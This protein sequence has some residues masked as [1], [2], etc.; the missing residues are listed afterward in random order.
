MKKDLFHIYIRNHLSVFYLPI[1]IAGIVLWLRFY[2]QGYPSEQE[3]K[4]GVTLLSVSAIFL[5]LERRFFKKILAVKDSDADS[6]LPIVKTVFLKAFYMVPWLMVVFWPYQTDYML[7]HILGFIF[8]FGAVGLYV[9][10][11]S[12][13]FVLFLTDVLF[14]VAAASVILFLNQDSIE[15]N[16]IFSALVLFTLYAL[17]IGRRLNKTSQELVDTNFKLVEA[18]SEAKNANMAKSDFLSMISHEIRTPMHGILSTVEHLAETDLSDQQKESLSVVSRCSETLLNMLNNILDISK[19]EAKKTEIEYVVFSLRTVIEDAV[20][21]VKHSAAEKGLELKFD[22]DEAVPDYIKSDQVKIQQ[23]L[24]NLL[25]NAIKFTEKGSVTISAF[26]AEDKKNIRVEVVDTGV[27]ISLENQK[28]LFTRFTQADASVTRHYGGTGLGLSIAKNF[29]HLM[30][31]DIGIESQEG[32]GSNFW[33][34]FPCKESISHASVDRH[35]N[36][37]INLPGNLFV[38]VADDNEINQRSVERI[39]LYQECHVTMVHNGKEAL[40]K[41]GLHPYDIILMDMN[42]PIMDGIEATRAL[43]NMAD[44]KVKSIPVIGL[45]AATDD[46]SIRKFYNSGIVDHITKPFKKYEFL[47][48]IAI[49]LSAEEADKPAEKKESKKQY[50]SK[51]MLVKLEEIREDFGDDFFF[52]FVEDSLKEIERLI[53]EINHAY[54]ESN[55][56]SLYQSAHDLCAVS[57][58]IGMEGTQRLAKRLELASLD[59]KIEEVTPP[60]RE[61]GEISAEEIESVKIR[62]KSD[63]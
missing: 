34:E 45:T 37:I 2:L 29:L 63:S 19:I 55:Y 8:V 14:Q 25:S 52:S 20:N 39:L 7:D 47:K 51:I 3:I 31:G 36:D 30:G 13:Y 60:Y 56:E 61:L 62:L 35:G 26:L 9:A 57:G 42:M 43:K 6:A 27:G 58:N 38:L 53:E 32:K 50:S 5:F 4:I 46:E 11:S 21:I 49:N 22:I 44:P 59:K 28:K 41:V 48:T 33:F 40:E 16:Y 10:I 15:T 17:F 1:L 12:P 24:L 54:K 23:I 18:A